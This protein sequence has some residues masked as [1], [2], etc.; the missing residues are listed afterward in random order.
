MKT[1]LFTLLM[2]SGLLLNGF[3][4]NCHNYWAVVS[5]DGNYLYFSSNRLGIDFD[6]YRCN[7]D[8][9]NLILLADLE[10]HD[11]F[12][13]VSPDGST[14]I[15]QNGNYGTTA[16]IYKVNNDGTNLI[17]L[18][19]NS[20]YDGF[21]NYSPDGQ[22]IVFAAWDTNPYPEVFMMD[23]DGGNRIQL[24][25]LTGAY[26][27]S[28]PKFNPAGNKIYFQAGFNADEHLA[29][30]DING[31]NWVDI[32]PVNNFGY[33]DANLF[34]S[35]DGTKIIFMN[36]DRL[37]YNNGSD[38]V[39]A[40]PDGTNWDYITNAAS[41][42]SYHQA[43]Y[44][45]TNDLLYITY[46]ATTSGYWNIYSMN[47]DGTN[48][49]PLANC[50]AA[51]VDELSG[52]N[53][54]KLFPSPGTGMLTIEFPDTNSE[55]KVCIYNAVGK[56]ILEQEWPLGKHQGQIQLDHLGNGVYLCEIFDGKRISNKKFII[57]K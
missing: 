34:F 48:K 25:E 5:P 35:P 54:L 50:S 4:Q 55:V 51:S 36:T 6:L 30:V 2:V 14:I 1:S 53:L 45:P 43:C 33:A 57:N 24:T 44:H 42:E 15:F 29:T 46:M 16:E 17:R 27:Q 19:D 47:Q 22:K 52:N 41:G 26:W 37:G 20:V 49:I 56:I 21:P 32:T 13:S 11:L 10:G 9:S 7:I 18:T 12:P 23:A 39:K 40:N 38:L 28:A 3:S 8:G 31:S